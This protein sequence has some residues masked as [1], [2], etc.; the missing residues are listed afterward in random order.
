MG[1]QDTSQPITTPLC[2]L[3]SMKSET[4]SQILLR[5][6]SIH[7]S[8]PGGLCKFWRAPWKAE[9]GEN[10]SRCEPVRYLSSEIER[11]SFMQKILVVRYSSD[12]PS[13]TFLKAFLPVKPHIV[14]FIDSINVY[15]VFITCH[16]LFYSRS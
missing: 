9:K 6:G 14:S 15:H 3:N 13:T 16:A 11:L 12:A 7:K 8:P 2:D 5:K 4:F 10:S 1:E